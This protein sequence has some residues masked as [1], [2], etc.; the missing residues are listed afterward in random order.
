MVA[1]TSQCFIFIGMSQFR[2]PDNF[3]NG[4][5]PPLSWKVSE[6]GAG[7]VATSPLFS[8]KVCEMWGVVKCWG[9]EARLPE[10]GSQ[11]CFLL[12]TLGKILH[13]SMFCIS[14]L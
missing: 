12:W 14:S 8:L 1:A 2:L 7:S 5:K 3:Y 6:A 10:L 9:S 13:L 4:G 11:L